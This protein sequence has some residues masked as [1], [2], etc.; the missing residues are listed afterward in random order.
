MKQKN[1]PHLSELRQLLQPYEKKNNKLAFLIWIVDYFL[2]F[3]GQYCVIF[4]SLTLKTLGSF[5]IFIAISRLFI[6]GHDASH[7]ALTNSPQLNYFFTQTTFFPALVTAEGW[8]QWH[9][10]VHHGFTNSA[11][12]DVWKPLS[13]EQFKQLNLWQ[14][15]LQKLYRNPI[16]LCF[17]YAMEIWWHIYFPFGQNLKG[18][19][20]KT[21]KSFI[22]EFLAV[23]LFFCVWI[24]SIFTLAK[25]TNQN[26]IVLIFY[27]F[28]LPFILWNMAMSFVIYLHH[29]HPNVF[30]YDN[31]EQ[32]KQ[33][34]TQLTATVHIR[35]P[36]WIS[37]LL[38]HIMEHPAHHINSRIPFYNLKAAQRKL[39]KTYPD[40]IV[41]Q[42]FSWRW[43]LECT[44]ICKLYD[45]EKH[46]W[47]G[48]KN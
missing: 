9:N 34:N 30:W 44:R 45:F 31:F 23:N 27:S 1:L 41:V 5:I 26:F 25:M 33:A 16:G 29:T 6:L 2:F 32:W 3:I 13:P 42:D 17:Y 36:D 28:L 18:F 37:A 43:Y 24:F 35:F 38:H 15:L 39:E 11:I 7:Q 4:E 20:F 10:I 22:L 40:Y 47:V 48:F 19:S 21:K 46:E 12:K 8:M 14:K